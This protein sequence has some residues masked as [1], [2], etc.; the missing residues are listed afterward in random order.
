MKRDRWGVKN[1][2]KFVQDRYPSQADDLFL[3]IRSENE[4]FNEQSQEKMYWDFPSYL[5][6]L[7]L[8]MQQGYQLWTLR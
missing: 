3:R 6:N 5:N 7:G 2:D 8:I 4:P 1:A